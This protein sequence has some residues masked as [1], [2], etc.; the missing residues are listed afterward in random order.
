MVTLLELE[1]QDEQEDYLTQGFSLWVQEN[2][3]FR[4]STNLKLLTK[5]IPGVYSLDFNRDY[6]FFCTKLPSL[7]DKLYYFTDSVTLR[8]IE[9]IERFWEKKEIYK[10]N[11]LVH[12]RGVLLT[13]YP[14][15]G[16]TSIVNQ[17]AK[18]IIDKGGVVFQVQGLKNLSD[19]VGFLKMIF[20]KIEPDT[21]VITIIEDLEEYMDAGSSL[22]DFFDGK[23][24]VDHHVIICT[25]NNTEELPESIL[26]PSRI[27]VQ[28][29]VPL[30]NEKTR[31]EY[32]SFLE[33]PKEDLD[34]LVSSTEHCSLAD[35]KEIYISVYLL[36]YSLEESVTKVLSPKDRKNFLFNKTPS[37]KIGF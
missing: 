25:S 18:G 20:R 8:L 19:Y 29:E 37:K 9:E 27:D 5:L 34:S 1:E 2:D 13:G 23:F 4:S 30:P 10:N 32:F 7:T 16:K 28:I 36:D 22:L 3:V 15:T 14:G 12:K 33:V 21:P 17:V 31:M 6:G 26:R 24:S 11:N 35:L